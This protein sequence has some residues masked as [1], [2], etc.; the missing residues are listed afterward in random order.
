MLMDSMTKIEAAEELTRDWDWYACDQEGNIGHFTTAGLRGLPRSVK[1]DREALECVGRYLLEERKEWSECSIRAG[2]EAD[3]GGWKNMVAR[4][5]YLRS[6]IQAARRGVFSY[7]TE[8]RRGSD[9]KYYL[10]AKPNKPLRTSDLPPEIGAILSKTHAPISFAI[11]EYIPE[12][13]TLD[14]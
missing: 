1:Q 2:V 6:F 3:A 12:G 14:W 9:A 5:R 4:D 13:E 10:V 11:R 8:M 7:N